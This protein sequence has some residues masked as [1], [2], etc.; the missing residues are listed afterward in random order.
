MEYKYD[1]VDKIIDF[2]TWDNR[3]KI[4]ELFRIDTYMYTNM[5]IDSTKTER[6]NAKKKSR[7]IYRAIQKIDPVVG[8]ELIH[9]MDK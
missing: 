6:D 1:D 8:K 7:Y 9:F 4:N 5:G 3:K 2:K